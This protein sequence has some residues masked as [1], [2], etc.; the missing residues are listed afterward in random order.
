M[1][2][3][4][5]EDF[6]EFKAFTA[7]LKFKDT[8]QL[9]DATKIELESETQKILHFLSTHPNLPSVAKLPLSLMALALSTMYSVA[10]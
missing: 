1:Q 8:T 6:N 5:M 4:T 9:T 3:P 2:K 7:S 10:P